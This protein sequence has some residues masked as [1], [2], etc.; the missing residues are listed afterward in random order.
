[1]LLAGPGAPPRVPPENARW[2]GW[3]DG[4]RKARALASAEVFVLPSLSEGM[5][6]A[7][8]EAMACGLAIVA[9]RVGGVPELLGE[10]RDASLVGPGDPAALATAL[11]ALAAEPERRRRLGEAAAE[12][13]RRLAEEDVYGRLDRIYAELAR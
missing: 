5:P 9:T 13:A 12:R 1:V 3:L 7:L 11:A 6:V 8:L 4:E 2:E 10:G